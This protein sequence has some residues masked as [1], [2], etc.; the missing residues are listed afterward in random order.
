MKII[1]CAG[2]SVR[3]GTNYMGSI[4]SEIPEVS[5]MPKNYSKGEFPFFRKPLVENYDNWVSNF[6][7][8]MFAR[9]AV[10]G[11]SLSKFVGESFL[12]Y[13]GTEYS[14]ETKNIFVKDPN[15]Y[16]VERFYDFFPR[17]KLII[18]T[19]SAPDLIA[20][21]LKASL[22]IRKSQSW[23]KKIKSRIKYYSGYNMFTYAKAYNRHPAQLD[24]LRKELNGRFYEIK[25][26]DLVNEPY[27][28]IPEILDYCEIDYDED[29]IEK[30]V[31]AKVVG[32]S[33]FGAKKESQN[34][35]TMEK[36]NKF[37]PIGRY[38]SWGWFN[39]LIYSRMASQSNKRVGYDHKL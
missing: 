5:S 13:I 16:N 11:A 30:A 19:R 39:K 17:G 38:E 27:K 2:I 6:N 37:N 32:S 34:W 8:K 21:S 9:P 14:I 29:V 18:L 28:F 26:E 35:G 25:Y 1:F 20:S 23:Q 7:E 10:N 22:Q 24:F 31:N 33:Y 12:N 15:L 3:T 36:T 4:F